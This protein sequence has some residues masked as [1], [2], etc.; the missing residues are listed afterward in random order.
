MRAL[1]AWP[2]L[3]LLI[4]SAVFFIYPVAQILWLSLIDPVGKPT[5]AYFIR[6]LTTPVYAR[7]LAITL[8][9]SAWTTVFSLLAGY[10]VAY[11]LATARAQTRDWL[12]LLV[13]MPF[14]TSFL[15][16]TFAWMILLGRNGAVNRLLIALGLTDAPLA[17]IFNMTGVMI[18]M[19][20]SM[21]PLGIIAMLSVMQRV[22]RRLVSAARTLGAGGGNAFW[23]I[24][25]RLSLPGVDSAGLLVFVSSLGF[26]ITPALLG[27][28][29]AITL[30]MLIASFVTDRL[31]WS[32]AA[33]G[34]LVL[35]VVVLVLLGLAA[36]LLPL[37]KGML[38]R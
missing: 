21:M 27:G 26:F 2:L 22:D 7:T 28:A 36:R 9:I 3:P 8:Q 14:W 30:S 11:L 37:D 24:F 25:F 20:H 6:A 17:L 38:A 13:L 10:P 19:V 15:V 35:L 34:S 5:L 29:N 32:L 33:A 4:F 1:R 18:G 16:R 12:T 23:R 31:A